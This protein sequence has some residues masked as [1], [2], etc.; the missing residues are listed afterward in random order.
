[1]KKLIL[2]LSV[3]LVFPLFSFSQKSLNFGVNGAY[4]TSWMINQN[5]YGLPEMEY[6]LKLS[7]GGMFNVTYN[8][9]NNISLQLEFDYSIRG[10]NYGGFQNKIPATRDITLTYYEIP[11]LFKYM[12]KGSKT[13][14][15]FL[16][17]P[18]FGM[19]KAAEQEYLLDGKDPGFYITPIGTTDSV[20]ASTTDILDRYNDSDIGVILDVGA[21]F[22]LNENWFLTA[23]LRFNYGFKD[24]NLPAW[25]IKNQ[26]GVYAATTNFSGGFVFGINYKFPIKE[27]TK[28]IPL[29]R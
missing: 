22:L 21:D 3:I 15:R 18:Y 29:Q 26:N 20:K 10:Q 2:L 17:G 23:A 28:S 8:F 13:R 24:V 19:L 27:K 12:G 25:Q 5:I 14:F 4:Y 11:I 16:A 7:S 1:M 9:N 6:N